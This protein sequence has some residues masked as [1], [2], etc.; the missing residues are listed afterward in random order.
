[1]GGKKFLFFF[2][3][4]DLCRLNLSNVQLN[5]DHQLLIGKILN[6]NLPFKELESLNYDDLPIFNMLN[7]ISLLE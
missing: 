6:I 4:N 1:M 2:Y 7:T 5:G 3:N